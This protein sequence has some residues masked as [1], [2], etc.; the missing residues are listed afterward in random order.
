[1]SWSYN[2]HTQLLRTQSEFL[3]TLSLLCNVTQPSNENENENLNNPLCFCCCYCHAHHTLTQHYITFIQPNQ[4]I[5]YKLKQ[6]RGQNRIELGF[7]RDN[8]M[9]LNGEED[10]EEEEKVVV[11]YALTSKKKKSFL[12]PN[13]IALARYFYFYFCTIFIFHFHFICIFHI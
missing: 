11:G 6:L 12:K 1:V 3:R 2:T 13:F 5:Y 9:K 7:L 10:E 4:T 8:K